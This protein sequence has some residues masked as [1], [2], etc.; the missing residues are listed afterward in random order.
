MAARTRS[1]CKAPQSARDART[2]DALYSYSTDTDPGGRLRIAC[3]NRRASRCPSCAWTYA[4]NTFHLIRSGL[5]GDPGKGIAPTVRA[6]PKVFATLSAPSFGPVHN[7][8]GSGRCR[9]GAVHPEG[10]AELGTPLDAERYDYAH[11]VLWN[12]HASSA[13]RQRTGCTPSTCSPWSWGCVG[14]SCWGS[15]GMRWTSTAR[16]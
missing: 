14:V 11:A 12:N 3:G 1:T 8:P 13:S 16:G 2:G 9:C 7:R 10:A 6:H 5:L 4:G 15:A